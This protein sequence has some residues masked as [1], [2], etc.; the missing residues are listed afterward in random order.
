MRLCATQT[1]LSC[2]GQSGGFLTPEAA[3]IFE[4]VIIMVKMT[5]SIGRLCRLAGLPPRPT[6]GQLPCHA[7]S[8]APQ[9]PHLYPRRAY[10]SEARNR[11]PRG[12]VSA[13][14]YRLLSDIPT[15]K[16][17]MCNKDHVFF[18]R[19]GARGRNVLRNHNLKNYVPTCC[20]TSSSKNYY[21]VRND[22][23]AETQDYLKNNIFW[24]WEIL[25]KT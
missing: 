5:F 10:Q 9:P 14:L 2:R 8:R 6:A 3:N 21:Y 24:P 13:P 22:S 11:K 20:V 17:K 25:F 15:R 23:W 19:R 1:Y 18:N 7:A 12:V 16:E 4:R